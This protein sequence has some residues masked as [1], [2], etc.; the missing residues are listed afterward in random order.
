MGVVA[1]LLVGSVL[2]FSSVAKGLDPYGTVLKIG[3][4]LHAM[5]LGWADGVATS[6]AV[7]LIGLEMVVGVALVVGAA[8]RITARVALVLNGLFMLLTLWVALFN[9]V[10]ECG[11][12]GDVLHLTN[13]QTFVKNVVLV[14]LSIV[15]LMGSKGRKGS[16]AS[17]VVALVALCCSI[18]LS[19][20][21]L[22]M[23]PLVERFPFGEGTNIPEAMEADRGQEMAQTFVVCRNTTS[24]EEKTFRVDDNEWWNEQQWEFVRV[25]S[26]VRNT[27]EVSI[28]DFRLTVG[29]LD[30]T[31]SL[32]MMP[33]CRLLCVERVESLSIKEIAALRKIAYDCMA[34]GDRVVVVTSSSLRKA[35]EIFDGTEIC[36]MDNTALRALLRAKAG[37]V[38]LKYGTIAQKLNLCR[39][40]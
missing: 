14:A 33:T 34:K 17:G 27:V 35:S 37:V 1:R 5:H 36:N 4:Y 24:G 32:L 30:M 38:T 11:C 25:E 16:V 3:E 39:L 10:A 13:W 8:P 20:Y 6:L 19:L 7:V 15:V 29:S 9:P 23:L 31:E 18:A 22:V 21:S 26:P 40:L 28:R 2:I 12:F